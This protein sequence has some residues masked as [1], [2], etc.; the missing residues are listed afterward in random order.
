MM[1]KILSLEN[2]IYLIIF[3]LP[4]Y[5]LKLTILGV[6]T[7]LLEILIIGAF[8][9]TLLQGLKLDNFI[10]P[11]FSIALSLILIGLIISAYLN[12]K[13]A[14]GAGIIKGWFILPI[15]L[16]LIAKSVI[17]KERIKNILYTLFFS[18]TAVSSLSL[19]GYFFG[20]VTFDG[21]LEGVFNSPNYLAMYIAPALIFGIMLIQKINFKN[22]EA[23]SRID[24]TLIIGSVIMTAALYLTYTYAAWVAVLASFAIVLLI[25]NKQK[26]RGRWFPILFLVGLLL[27]GS[28]WNSQKFKDFRMI[29][30]RSSSE[31]RIMIW[32]A[33]VKIIQDNPVFG[34]GAGNFQEKYLEYQRYFPPYLEW[35]VPHPHSLYLAFW[36]YSGI[37]GLAAFI[38][39]VWMWFK[40][41]FKKEKDAF[42]MAS[43][44]IMIYF[45]LHGLV[46]T[47]Y[48]KNDLAVIFWLNFMFLL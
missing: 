12:G 9:W 6:P 21:R 43:V 16:A 41:I 47:T 7:N 3:L 17:P 48:F 40:I 30:P 22:N 15:I 36:L 29:N 26:I 4:S 39:L 10:Q 44:C 45:L 14:I 24:K 32:K 13:Y 33:A 8:F 35:A 34:I 1:K 11:K 25:Q 27:L 28:Q 31:S 19:A 2:F 38:Y 23:V 5:L 18:A 20:K 46:D 37:V 42:W